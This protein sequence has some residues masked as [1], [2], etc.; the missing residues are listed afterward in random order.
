MDMFTTLILVMVSQ[1]KPYQMIEFKY[2]Q[3]PV[4]QS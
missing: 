4:S 1:Y 3:F 2:T